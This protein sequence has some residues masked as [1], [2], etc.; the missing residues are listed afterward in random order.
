MSI[1]K[2]RVK[3]IIK[4]EYIKLISESRVRLSTW[5][6]ANFAPGIVQ[7]LGKKGKVAMDRK[8]VSALVKAVRNTL[9]RSFT[10]H[11]VK[12]G[13]PG[14][15]PQSDE[16]NPFDREPSD[17]ELKDIE[18]QF[19]GKLTEG[20]LDWEKHFPWA[21]G[22]ELK[23]IAKVISMHKKGISGA[24]ATEKENPSVFKK[25]VKSAA[26]RGLGEGK[27]TEKNG[28]KN[29]SKKPVSKTPVSKTPVS[30][31]PV[32]KTPSEK[33]TIPKSKSTSVKKTSTKKGSTSA[34]IKV[35]KYH[36]KSKKKKDDEE[37]EE[38]KLNEGKTVTLPNG[39][40]VKIE[41][42]GITLKGRHNPVFLDRT[43]MM[44]FFKAT[45]RYLK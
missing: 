40:K 25:W 37:L 42:K 1:T 38:G 4:E 8:S 32:S 14:S 26:K 16:D 33:G 39:V 22:K 28:I 7:L 3:Q 23:V 24:L 12:E 43:E 21:K 15:G 29:G 6:D 11:E 34:D 13:G 30:K 2:N 27:L 41:F 44:T 35:D 10:T 9:G 45:A 5:K 36:V 18:K 20:S 19:E 17:D 31:T